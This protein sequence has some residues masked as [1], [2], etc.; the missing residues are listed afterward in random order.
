MT[1]LLLVTVDVLFFS[2]PYKAANIIVNIRN[3]PRRPPS[4][5]AILLFNKNNNLLFGY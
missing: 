2:T 1:Y 5:M 4:P 3:I